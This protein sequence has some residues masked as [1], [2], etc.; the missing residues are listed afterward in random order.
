[1]NA[2]TTV[3]VGDAAI[4]AL[5]LIRARSAVSASCSAAR[6]EIVGVVPLLAHAARN[7]GVAKIREAVTVR[8][9]MFLP[10]ELLAA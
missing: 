6:G 3:A 10:L 8:R 4:N 1:M 7:A 9:F 5:T 2:A